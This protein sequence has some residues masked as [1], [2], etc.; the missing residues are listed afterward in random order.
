MSKRPADLPSQPRP[1]KLQNTGPLVDLGEHFLPDAHTLHSM[2]REISAELNKVYPNGFKQRDLVEVYD[3]VQARSGDL[4]QPFESVSR[5]FLFSE[6]WNLHN[7]F[8]EAYR[9]GDFKRIML[10]SQ[11]RQ[12]ASLL[13]NL[14]AAP[15]HSQVS[16]P[17][18]AWATPFIGKSHDVLLL[19]LQRMYKHSLQASVDTSKHLSHTSIIQSSGSGKSRMVDEVSKLMFA[20]PFNI[21]KP[22]DSKVGAWPL[23]DDAIRELLVRL[24]TASDEAR[25]TCGFLSFFQGVF[26]EIAHTVEREFKQPCRSR[27]EFASSW[28]AY[29]SSGN[30]RSE[31]YRRVVR[32]TDGLL[33]ESHKLAIQQIAPNTREALRALVSLVYRLSSCSIS[34]ESPANC[35]Q[36]LIYFDEAHDLVASPALQGVTKSPLDVLVQALDEF[37]RCGAFTLLMSTQL[38]TPYVAPSSPFTNSAR[39]VPR[40]GTMHAPITETPF[41]CFGSSKLIPSRLKVGDV[42]KVALMACFGRPMWRAMLSPYSDHVLAEYTDT[43]GPT[44]V[45][46]DFTLWSAREETLLAFARSKLLCCD[47]LTGPM[48]DYPRAARTAVID[49][50]IMLSYGAHPSAQ[51]YQMDLVASHVRTVYSIPRDRECIYSGYSSEPVLAEAAARQLALWRELEPQNPDNTRPL[52]EPAVAILQRLLQQDLLARGET[53]EIGKT[54]GRLLLLLARDNAARSSSN[55]KQTTHYSRPIS[56][57]AFITALFPTD[58]AERILESVPD[59]QVPGED[60][61]TFREVFK[62]AVLNF[63]HYAKWEDDSVLS[64]DGALGCFIRHLAGI[65]GDRKAIVDAFLPILM[66]RQAPL[67]PDVMSGIFIQFKL[68]GKAGIRSA[69]AIDEEAIGFFGGDGKT[70]Q[71]YITLIMELGGTNPLPL[72]ERTPTDYH[73]P[74]AVLERAQIARQGGSTSSPIAPV[75]PSQAVIPDA[76]V[77]G[78]RLAVHPRYSMYVYGCSP[79]VYKVIGKQERGIYKRIIRSGDLL[80]EHPRQ[81]AQSLAALRN[82]KPFFDHA[83]LNWLKKEALKVDKPQSADD[84]EA[85]MFCGS[86]IAGEGDE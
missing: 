54:V 64:E 78:H 8:R 45:S 17:R 39:Y 5:D 21:R 15:R 71:P 22:E 37:E 59:N 23:P 57:E 33:A 68:R 9:T 63:T 20:I 60:T 56:V 70:L 85:G 83:S 66:D 81:D 58:I 84:T 44:I 76:Q 38:H 19:N 82:Q 32:R 55:P 72:L 18:E 35:L 40:V 73:S 75:S 10:I 25:M 12:P 31:L 28:H 43:D 62:D 26:G 50:R 80:G 49:A 13:R 65:C 77:R 48:T 1:A 69:Y 42:G 11:L 61:K 67:S 27:E 2:N 34:G 7:S 46:L 6:G 86:E 47:K 41:D 16:V 4:L 24:G 3:I 14:P 30:H 79:S 52:I 74:T 51:Q 29:L 36:V 53:G